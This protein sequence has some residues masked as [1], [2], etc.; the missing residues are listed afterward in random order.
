MENMKSELVEIKAKELKLQMLI[1]ICDKK[2]LSQCIRLLSMYLAIYKSHYG[3]LPP[4]CYE[5][6]LKDHEVDAETAKIFE[7]GM[8]EA[9][10]ILDM[11]LQVLP[12]ASYQPEGVTIN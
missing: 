2:E 6:I 8:S 1:E 5:N 3:E 4:E 7:N 11:V 12:E 10:S 9:L